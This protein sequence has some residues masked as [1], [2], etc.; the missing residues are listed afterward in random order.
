[1]NVLVS[2]EVERRSKLGLS[3]RQKSSKVY[4][5]EVSRVE[6][7][8]QPGVDNRKVK[9]AEK[10]RAKEEKFTAAL[11]AVSLNSPP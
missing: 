1:M 2:E 8:V 5:V 4:E 9:V 7:A 3:I 6:G 11:E 10:D